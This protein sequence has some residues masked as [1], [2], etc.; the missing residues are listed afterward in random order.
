VLARANSDVASWGGEMRI[1]YLP[2]RRRFDTRLEAIVGENHNP[3]TVE[4]FVR[5]SAESLGIPFIDVA[6]RFASDRNPREL[7]RDRRLHYNERG[8]ATVAQAIIADLQQRASTRIP[9]SP[10]KSASGDSCTVSH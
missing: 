9:S 7:W 1:V 8:Y 3:R 4:R 6:T 2:E 5:Q 10:C